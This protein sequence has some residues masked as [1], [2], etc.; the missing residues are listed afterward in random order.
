MRIGII[1]DVHGNIEALTAVLE[2][3]DRR[4]VDQLVCLG[5][6]LGYGADPGPCLELI[7]KRCDIVIL[8][9]HDAAGSGRMNLDDYYP[10]AK[11]A[12]AYAWEH[13]NN[14][15]RQ[16]IANLP[17]TRQQGSAL[18]CHGAPHAPE[19]FDYLFSEDQAH[20]Y[21]RNFAEMPQVTF[22]GHSHLTVGF[23]FTSETARGFVEPHVQMQPG[24]KYIFTVGSVGQP[25]DRDVRSCCVEY[26]TERHSV[27]YI[28]VPY[29]FQRTQKRIIDAGLPQ[30]FALRLQLGM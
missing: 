20:T 15:Q 6:I 14:D 9:N 26:D 27:D 30:T 8:G 5:D 1:S 18:F 12:I 4:K 19:A 13:I 10:E 2:E 11:R 7:M 24:H 28:R 3:L 23:D 29:D 21:V 16:F 17:Y 22:I 25:R